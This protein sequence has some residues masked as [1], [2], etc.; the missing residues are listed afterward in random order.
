MKIEELSDLQ[1]AFQIQTHRN[2]IDSFGQALNML[3]MEL[4]KRLEL[5]KQKADAQKPVEKSV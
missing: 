4:N 5:E 3:L 2:Q 1:L